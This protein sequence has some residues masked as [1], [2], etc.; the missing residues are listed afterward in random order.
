MSTEIKNGT[1]L[2]PSTIELGTRANYYGKLLLNQKNCKSLK[3]IVKEWNAENPEQYI[4]YS[5][6]N[7]AIKENH[8]ST[9]IQ[10]QKICSFLEVPAPNMFF[11]DDF[12]N[13]AIRYEHNL[14]MD[15]LN[16]LNIFAKDHINNHEGESINTFNCSTSRFNKTPAA[17]EKIQIARALVSLGCGKSDIVNNLYYRFRQIE[18]A[19]PH[20][21]KNGNKEKELAYL[22]FNVELSQEWD[23]I[24]TDF[25]KPLQS[26]DN[27]RFSTYDEWDENISCKE[28]QRKLEEKAIHNMYLL[29]CNTDTSLRAIKQDLQIT[30][31]YSNSVLQRIFFSNEPIE[32]LFHYIN[33]KIAK[34]EL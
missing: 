32:G 20:A 2:L 9:S 6:I 25:D 12:P 14:V 16:Q 31:D 33:E 34:R 5:T 18:F 4:P 3:K 19:H 11:F 10:F 24:L 1:E 29:I 27:C 8:S 28:A 7:D 15:I 17:H 22:I 21:L 30:G 23:R 13:E 26:T